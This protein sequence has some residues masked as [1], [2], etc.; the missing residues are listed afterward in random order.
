[1]KTRDFIDLVKLKEQLRIEIEYKERLRKDIAKCRTHISRM[2]RLIKEI[3]EAEK[4]N[5]D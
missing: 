1:M 4:E 3:E 5:E 2:K